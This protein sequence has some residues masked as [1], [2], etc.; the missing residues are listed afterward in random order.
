[1]YAKKE[2]LHNEGN[3]KSWEIKLEDI[4]KY[5]SKMISEDKGLAMKIMLPKVASMVIVVRKP[6]NSKKAM[7]LMAIISTN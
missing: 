3:P 1:M 5:T 6:R 2:R 4:K 7:S